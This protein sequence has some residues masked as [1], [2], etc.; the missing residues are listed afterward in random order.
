MKSLF[1]YCLAMLYFL[2]PL[3]AEDTPPTG[4]AKA[5]SAVDRARN[6]EAKA[7]FQSAEESFEKKDYER[8]L[9]YLDYCV[10]ALGRS[11]DKILLLKIQTEAELAK[12]DS[13][14]VLRTLRTIGRLERSPEFENISDER[15]LEV[16]K[17]KLKFKEEIEKTGIKDETGDVIQQVAKFLRAKN[18]SNPENW[19][20]KES[21]AMGVVRQAADANEAEAQ[22]LLSKL[23]SVG[24]GFGKNETEARKWLEK[25]AGQ[26]FPAA[27]IELEANPREEKKKEAGHGESGDKGGTAASLE[28][29]RSSELEKT[30]GGPAEKRAD[31]EP[32]VGSWECRELSTLIIRK[33]DSG[34]FII[35]TASQRDQGN[36]SLNGDGTLTW[37]VKTETEVGIIFSKTLVTT[38]NGEFSIIP[39][40]PNKL[41]YKESVK[42]QT[43][44]MVLDETLSDQTQTYTLER[45]E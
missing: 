26:K 29:R 31:R 37:Q 2:L 23:Y 21:E 8:T 13:T 22:F 15:M 40:A 38:K 30:T 6:L 27:E 39:N 11:P 36:T 25:A 28:S 18:F 42:Q 5:V 20:L 9:K 17:L 14:Y 3:Q 19:E 35:D 7:A 45:K 43:V 24:L 10:K 16:M 34:R 1:V 32:F 41:K 4:T 33:G 44:G 12:T